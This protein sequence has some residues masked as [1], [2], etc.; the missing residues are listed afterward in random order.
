M[1]EKKKL[2][3]TVNYLLVGASVGSKNGIIREL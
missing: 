3:K 2:T 1:A